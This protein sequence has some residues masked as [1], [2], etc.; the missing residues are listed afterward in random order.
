MNA[1]AE[2]ELAQNKAAE[3]RM[4]EMRQM[5]E[6]RGGAFGEG[7]LGLQRS[8]GIIAAPITSAFDANR[9][10]QWTKTVESL[11][12]DAD[13]QI[14]QAIDQ[15]EAL[16]KDMTLLA[17]H[18]EVGDVHSLVKLGPDIRNS[19]LGPKSSKKRVLSSKTASDRKR[20]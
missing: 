2:A 7:S 9:L 19:H 11:A 1:S 20:S 5:I 3:A 8:P 10:E 6:R 17:V 13:K 16:V 15:S 12:E 14:A 18:D 4:E